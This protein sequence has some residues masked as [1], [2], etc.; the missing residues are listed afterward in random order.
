MKVHAIGVSAEVDGNELRQITSDPVEA[1]LSL[2]NTY[3]DLIELQATLV[4][5]IC[6]GVLESLGNGNNLIC[7][8]G[9]I[10]IRQN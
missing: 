8:G 4:R 1:H 5:S 7:L 6:S 2:A 3:D 10:S 9:A